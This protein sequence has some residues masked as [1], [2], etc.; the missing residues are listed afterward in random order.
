MYINAL[1]LKNHTHLYVSVYVYKIVYAC[2]VTQ[3]A[4]LCWRGPNQRHAIS[5]DL[6]LCQVQKERHHCHNRLCCVAICMYINVHICIY[7][8]ICMCTPPYMYAHMHICTNTYMYI[9][10]Y[11]YIYFQMHPYKYVYM[12]I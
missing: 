1:R 11:I 10:V 3:H 12:Y 6:Q 8:N 4:I 2:N 9:Y 5:L 7:T